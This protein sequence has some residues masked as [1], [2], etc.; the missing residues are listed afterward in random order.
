MSTRDLIDAIETGE[1]S[2]IE[3]SFNNIMVAKVS[4]RLDAMRNDMSQN[5]FRAPEAVEEISDEQVSDEQVS[6]E[7]EL[8]AEEETTEENE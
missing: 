1:S 7:T 5:M 6:D 3:A 8:Q 4:E 2:K